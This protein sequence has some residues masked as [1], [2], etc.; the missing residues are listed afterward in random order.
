LA[1]TDYQCRIE[2]LATYLQG[3][4]Q[5]SLTLRSAAEN[6]KY[7]VERLQVLKAATAR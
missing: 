7:V 2:H 3:F 4:E 5:E 1:L 6:I